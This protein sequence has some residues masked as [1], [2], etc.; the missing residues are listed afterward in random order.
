MVSAKITAVNITKRLFGE[1][2]VLCSNLKSNSSESLY[3]LQPEHTGS[4]NELRTN[5]PQKIIYAKKGG[6]GEWN[7]I[8]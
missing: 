3:I 8:D 4:D 5:C 1:G 7:Y 2:N 6:K